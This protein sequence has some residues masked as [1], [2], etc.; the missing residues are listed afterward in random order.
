MP[1]RLLVRPSLD[2]E[3]RP[4]L[5]ALENRISSLDGVRKTRC[6]GYTSFCR[7]G[8][9]F[10]NLE[11]RRDHMHLD[12][13]LEEDDLEAARASGIARPHPFLGDPVVRVRFER[14]EDL[15]R[16]GRWLEVSHRTAPNR[17]DPPPAAAA[18]ER[19]VAVA[20]NGTSEAEPAPEPA[21]PATGKSRPPSRPARPKAS[22]GRKRAASKAG[23]RRKPAAR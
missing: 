16:V 21:K 23:P 15:T 22:D 14:A 5:R 1:Y 2:V 8:V 18:G 12:L 7:D 3:L 19:P 10:L 9:P 4:L 20:P 11:I 6:D 17:A 13:W